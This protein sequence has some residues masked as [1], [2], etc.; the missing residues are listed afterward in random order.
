MLFWFYVVNKM[1][2]AV[3]IGLVVVATMLQE[4]VGI[5]ARTKLHEVLADCSWIVTHDYIPEH[6]NRYQH[7]CGSLK[8]CKLLLL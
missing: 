3:H 7:Q 8:Y 6:L 5:L 1:S 2:L 4:N